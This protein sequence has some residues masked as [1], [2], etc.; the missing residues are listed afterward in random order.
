MDK[1]LDEFP[2]KP[3]IYFFKSKNG[4]IL[5]IGKA[6]DIRKRVK[7][8]F[9]S[10]SNVYL[11]DDLLKSD[12]LEVDYEITNSEI[13]ALLLEAKMIRKYKPRY[14]V[15][16]KDDTSYPYILITNEKFPRILMIRKFKEK[17]TEGTYYGPFTNVTSVKETINFIQRAWKIAT[18]KYK[19]LPKRKC[20]KY[21]IKLCSAPCEKGKI[22]DTLYSKQISEVKEFLG[23]KS[24][25]KIIDEK[26]KE[27][28][29]LSNELRFEEAAKLRDQIK[30]LS[31]T[32]ENYR[33]RLPQYY[34]KNSL[35]EIK[36]LL[37]LP[38]LPI[39]IEAF[40]ISNIKS[41]FTVG[42]MVQFFEGYPNKNNYRR[43]K[44]RMEGQND[45]AM[46]QEI[47]RRRYSRLKREGREFPDLVLIDGGKSQLNGALKE[48]KEL[49]INLNVIALAKE[50]DNIY[51]KEKNQIKQ[52]NLISSSPALL[53]LK[54]VRDEV[55]RF[56]IK[57]HRNIRSK[58]F[59]K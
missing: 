47:I 31:R 57:Y 14:N 50:F 33:I 2:E 17:K 21:Q 24:R 56:A 39:T 41:Q 49:D 40:D 25:K 5:Y 55:H 53:F 27:M 15:R 32:I 6:N 3:G 8:H 9:K 30:A 42:A 12:F 58:Q 52:F 36:N 18:C 43:F 1:N 10:S 45:V 44:I 46:I 59:K 51:I 4:E 23:G 54:R 13:D 26:I 16:Q 28:E 7:S 48:L 19:K 34:V 29:D 38:N 22:T 20:L 35:K 37:N 11:K